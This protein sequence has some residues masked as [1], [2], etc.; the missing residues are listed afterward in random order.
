MKRTLMAI[1]MYF[2]LFFCSIKTKRYPSQRFPFLDGISGSFL[3][4][5]WLV[6]RCTYTLLV[7]AACF[8]CTIFTASSKTNDKINIT[9]AI[10]VAL[11]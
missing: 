7:L 8:I 5:N 9:S 3:K 1:K 6:S 10:A 11:A 4:T 2:V